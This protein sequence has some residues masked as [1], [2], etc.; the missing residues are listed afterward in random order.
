MLFSFSGYFTFCGFNL[1]VDENITVDASQADKTA[2][3]VR[4]GFSDYILKGPNPS[5]YKE[6]YTSRLNPLH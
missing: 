4:C 6:S 1:L 3:D 2:R 5:A